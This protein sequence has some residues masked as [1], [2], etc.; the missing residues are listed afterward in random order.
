LCTILNWTENNYFKLVESWHLRFCVTT[1]VY[2]VQDLGRQILAWRRLYTA[3]VEF[4]YPTR[5]DRFIQNDGDRK[6]ELLSLSLQYNYL[7]WKTHLKHALLCLFIWL[8]QRKCSVLFYNVAFVFQWIKRF[9]LF[10]KFI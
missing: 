9:Y 7:N 1:D 4:P 8:V 6:S 2:F 5:I 10:I 3:W